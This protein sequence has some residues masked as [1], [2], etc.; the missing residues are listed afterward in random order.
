MAEAAQPDA[1]KAI[2]DTGALEVVR[3]I[4]VDA[5]DASASQLRAS[6]LVPV[7]STVVATSY[8]SYV[9]GGGGGGGGG[10]GAIGGGIGSVFNGL[11]ADELTSQLYGGAGGANHGRHLKSAGIGR[12]G[13]GIGGGGGGAGLYRHGAGSIRAHSANV[14][15]GGGGGNPHHSNLVRHASF[16]SSRA[17]PRGA[18][19][20]N[21]LLDHCSGSA[22]LGDSAEVLVG[23]GSV[24]SVIGAGGGGQSSP[25]FASYVA[26]SSYAP[27]SAGSHRSSTSVHLCHCSP[28]PPPPL[29]LPN[30]HPLHHHHHHQ[31]QHHHPHHPHH[32]HPQAPPSLPS[33]PSPSSQVILPT[34][35]YSRLVQSLPSTP[36]ASRRPVSPMRPSFC[37]PPPLAQHPHVHHHQHPQLQQ[38]HSSSQ[39]V[40]IPMSAAGAAIHQFQ[41]QQQSIYGGGGGGSVDGNC[42]P[43]MGAASSGS[44]NR[45]VFHPEVL[46][47]QG[48]PRCPPSSANASSSAPRGLRAFHQWTR[49]QRQR[50][51]SRGRVLTTT[52][53]HRSS[54]AGGVQPLM[55]LSTLVIVL[56]AVLIIGFIVLSPLFHYLM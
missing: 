18:A 20:A 26:A 1:V 39:S 31:Q 7:T 6:S 47:D 38:Q 12:G 25:P 24:G 28:P 32:H 36:N 56:L 40:T 48:L 35:A 3:V 50:S 30:H 14:G 13:T 46:E 42:M 16:G 29:P 4:S 43:P 37:Q 51:N 5:A 54:H 55:K 52:A 33:H 9:G 34:S 45:V 10:A 21:L 49:G 23:G 15:A 53:G 2:F 8:A 22:L 41:H 11:T 27:S 44:V 19:T 17:S